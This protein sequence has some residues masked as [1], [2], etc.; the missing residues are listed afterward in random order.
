MQT[1]SGSACLAFLQK[2]QSVVCIRSKH[3]WCNLHALDGR[4]PIGSASKQQE[5][6]RALQFFFGHAPLMAKALI[7]TH[8]S[9]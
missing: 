1:E 8:L 9:S 7:I 4:H 6:T 5:I 2:L 3:A